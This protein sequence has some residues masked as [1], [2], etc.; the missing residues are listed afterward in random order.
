MITDQDFEDFPE[1]VISRAAFAHLTKPVDLVKILQLLTI[2]AIDKRGNS[3]I[4]ISSVRL[5]FCVGKI[6][7]LFFC[8]TL[9]PVCSVG[10]EIKTGRLVLNF[11]P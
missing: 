3:L 6:F 9:I 1:Q 10:E 5:G 11:D 7:F 4:N 2:S 8:I